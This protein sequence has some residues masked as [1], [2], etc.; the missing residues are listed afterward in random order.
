MR[1]IRFL[2][3]AKVANHYVSKVVDFVVYRVVFCVVLHFG[4]F[5]D[6]TG[7]DPLPPLG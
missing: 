7:A 4:W 3:D 6:G 1:R 2:T 5:F